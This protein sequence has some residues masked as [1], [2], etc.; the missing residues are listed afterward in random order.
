MAAVPSSGNKRSERIKKW[1]SYKND[2]NG[3]PVSIL[4][5]PTVAFDTYMLFG[6]M[7]GILG[8]VI[9]VKMMAWVACYCTLFCASNY[10]SQADLRQLLSCFLVSGMS[11]LMLYSKDPSPIA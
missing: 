8:V 4:D 10:R 9:Q 7:F 2:M 6:M 5:E 1:E 3:N 11:L